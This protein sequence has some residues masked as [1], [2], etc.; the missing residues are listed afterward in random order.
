MSYRIFSIKWITKFEILDYWI[1]INKYILG[2]KAH[3]K[4][5]VIFWNTIFDKEYFFN[6][7]E[8]KYIPFYTDKYILKNDLLSKVNYLCESLDYIKLNLNFV[9]SR[10][11][12]KM[13]DVYF[14]YKIFSEILEFYNVYYKNAWIEITFRFW[15]SF[16]KIPTTL[17][18]YVR[19]IDNDYNEDNIFISDILY[20]IVRDYISKLPKLIYRFEVFWP[21]ELITMWVFSKIM[22]KTNI[23]S[24]IV[25]D[26]SW[27]NEQFDFSQWIYFIEDSWKTMFS[28]F[29]Y[30]IYNRDFWKAINDLKSFLNWDKTLEN[31]TN[32]M[33]YDNWVKY[34]DENDNK[35]DNIERIKYFI[36]STFI[37]NKIWNIFWSRAIFWRFLPYKCYWNNCSFCTINTQNK[38]LFEKWYDYNFFLTKWVDFIENNKI[39][40][41]TFR[42]EAIPP[43]VIVDFAKEIIKRWLKINYQ[44]RTRYDKIFTNEICELLYKSW[45]RYCWMW[46]ESAVDRV[47]QEIGNKGNL[48]IKLAEKSQIIKN[49]DSNWIWV[50]NY[51]IIWFPWETE[52]ESIWTFKFLSQH[53]LNTNYF[54]CTPNIFWLMKGSKIFKNLED[55]WIKIEKKDIENPFNLRYDYSVNWKWVNYNFLKKLE[56]ELHRQ[57]FNP[58][59][60]DKN[61]NYRDFWDFIDRSFIFYLFKRFYKE[62]PYKEYYNINRELLKK[63]FSF[64]WGAFFEKSVYFKIINLSW[65]IFLKDV[66]N[67]VLK[68]VSDIEVDFLNNYNINLTLKSNLFNYWRINNDF[69][70]FIIDKRILIEIK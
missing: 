56:N 3:T 23:Y 31:I 19:Y 6:F 32:L 15:V 25:I 55:Y 54:T 63:D 65:K 59:L 52:I 60:E 17:D 53:I 18:E 48:D 61:I 40:I 33:Y 28:Y 10:K 8:N 27:A 29:D 50:H 9:D 44:F 4:L 1:D 20:P 34:I 14:S 43:F 21:E 38:I 49:F 5:W 51:S 7:I 46:L 45:L 69:I 26:F 2:K 11:I 16:L 41:V 58:W 68:E 67:N 66:L 70:L 30:F 12:P 22:K 39:E 36:E 24:P 42:D 62:S 47:N 35:E 57:Q 13:E 37:E 64:V